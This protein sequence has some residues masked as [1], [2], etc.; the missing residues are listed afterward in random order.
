MRILIDIP[1]EIREPYPGFDYTSK[2]YEA[3]RHLMIAYLKEKLPEYTDT[4]Q[5]D[6][7]IVIIEALAKGLDILSYYQDTIANEAF[8]ITAKD[9]ESG[10]RWS[11]G[12]GYVPKNRT[13][14]RYK[15]V[16][17]L[18][19]KLDDDFII[20]KGT[21]VRTKETMLEKSEIFEV[22][23]DFTIPAGFLGN[24][25]DENDEY[26]FTTTICHGVSILNELLG[27]STEQPDQEFKLRFKSVLSDGVR[28]YI[29][30]STGFIEWELVKTFIDSRPNDRQFTIYVN[31]SD[32]T[33]IM[34][35]NGSS[36]KIPESFI[37]G[38]YANYR[39]GGGTAG[40]VPPKSIC[41][42]LDNIAY[43]AE[44]FNP[45]PAFEFGVEPE[46]LEEIKTNAP[47]YLRTL[48]RAVHIDDHSDLV[49]I[50]FN[51]VKFAKAIQN[52]YDR[53]M[54]DIWVYLKNNEPLTPV[55]E[56][57][58][59]AFFEQRKMV[60][61]SVKIHYAEF[62]KINIECSLIIKDD[63]YIS[64]VREQTKEFLY[65]FFEL[66]NI[67]FNTHIPLTL[68]EAKTLHAIQGLRSFRITTP[69]GD[70]IVP[71]P[72][73]ITILGDLDMKSIGGRVK[74]ND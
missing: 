3:F 28:V 27:T 11:K 30:E 49:L 62:N 66:G 60:G 71:K 68:I 31:D 47:A 44:T 64:D 17:V 48:W 7:G 61:N 36:G 10:V 65:E 59:Y 34:F 25:K 20:P 38:I 39:V 69:V 58:L 53:N 70:V 9:R 4:S 43:I 15:Q 19:H 32:E 22:E 72:Y 13:P 40:N 1:K 51:N 67:D 14:A 16:F 52:A 46:T 24:E 74:T 33:I 45:Y 12:I 5:T 23:S 55:F 42:M 54:A 29:N 2:D 18:T 50:N 41:E 35:G 26:K 57:R 63:Y 8:F 73:E 6:A 21:K 37:D 56:E